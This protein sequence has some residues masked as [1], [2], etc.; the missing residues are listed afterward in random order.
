MEDTTSE[1]FNIKTGIRKDNILSLLTFCIVLDRVM[2]GVSILKKE[3]Q[4]K[5]KKWGNL[6]QNTPCLVFA[7]DLSILADKVQI[8]ITVANIRKF[9]KCSWLTGA[10][11]DNTKFMTPKTNTKN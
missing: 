10:L 8:A 3:N 6:S 11:W 5:H 2:D 7:D 9:F 1:T 4:W